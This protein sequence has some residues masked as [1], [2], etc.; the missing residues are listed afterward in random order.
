MGGIELPV[1]VF[2][3]P[4]ATVVQ[5]MRRYNKDGRS[6]P[7]YLRRTGAFPAPIIYTF[8]MPQPLRYVAPFAPHALRW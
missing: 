7:F 1:A 4:F 5:E 2:P 6:L 8:H 3:Y